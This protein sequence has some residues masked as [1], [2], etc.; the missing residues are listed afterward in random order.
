MSLEDIRHL[1]V[2]FF[3]I[4][5]MQQSSRKLR[6][7]IFVGKLASK[8]ECNYFYWFWSCPVSILSFLKNGHFKMRSSGMHIFLLDHFLSF[9]KESLTTFVQSEARYWSILNMW[10]MIPGHLYSTS[11]EGYLA[12]H[13]T[14]FICIF[15]L[16]HWAC[17]ES[18]L[19]NMRLLKK[20]FR[21]K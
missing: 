11:W 16:W 17:W 2:L 3:L 10:E 12:R 14:L 20:S 7:N 5:P 13:T 18:S 19:W 1:E 8:K 21:I 9:S 15:F 6:R 4:F